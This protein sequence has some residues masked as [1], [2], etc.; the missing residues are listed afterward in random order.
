MKVK[1]FAIHDSKIN[2]HMAPFTMLNEHQAIRAFSDMVNSRDHVIGQN[3]GD[4]TLFELGEFDD[5][6]GEI[7][8]RASRHSHANGVDLRNLSKRQWIHNGQIGDVNSLEP[9]SEGGITSE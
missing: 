8:P 6:S 2:A 4:Y 3:P 5:N 1:I 9:N 7:H